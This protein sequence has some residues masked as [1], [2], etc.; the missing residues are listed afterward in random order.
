MKFNK[1][2]LLLNLGHD[3]QGVCVFDFVSVVLT[4]QLRHEHISLDLA[5]HIGS[6]IGLG[7]NL[8]SWSFASLGRLHDLLDGL[9]LGAM[10]HRHEVAAVLS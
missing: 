8:A 10:T 6:L 2:L 9:A 5:I 3:S 7:H 4:V 1:R